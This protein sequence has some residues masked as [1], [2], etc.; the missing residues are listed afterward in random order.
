MS[1]VI[2]MLA[3]LGAVLGCRI[4]DVSSNTLGHLRFHQVP[5]E[6]SNGTA[7]ASRRPGTH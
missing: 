5:L 1:S 2:L 6:A 4:L 3:S 7:T